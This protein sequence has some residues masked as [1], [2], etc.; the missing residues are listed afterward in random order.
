MPAQPLERLLAI[1]ARLRDPKDGCPWDRQQTYATIVP[2]TLEEAYEVADAIERGDWDGLPDEL[3]DLLYQVVFYARLGEEEG[4]FD[5]H[6]IA[7]RICAKLERRHPQLFADEVSRASTA[8]SG[9]WEATKAQ[10]RAAKDLHSALDDLPLALPALSRSAKIQK[11]VAAVG[12]DWDSLGPVAAK[13]TEELD[14][15][16]VEALA[17]DPDHKRVEEELGDLLFAVTN[18][19][20]HLK[21]DPEQALRRANYKFEQ[22][23][24]GVEQLCCQHEIP[25][26]QAGLEQL[27]AFWQ[28]VKLQEKDS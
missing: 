13:V 19:A 1:M 21:V 4:R 2:H 18:L 9:H 22:R 8:Q 23:F 14:E 12:F 25:V 7:A 11:R 27:E 3:G 17:A 16:M 28:D 6:Q 10:E 24:R 20:R 5:F 15:V 26:N